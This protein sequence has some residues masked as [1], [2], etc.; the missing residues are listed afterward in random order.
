VVAAPNPSAAGAQY[1]GSLQLAVSPM[2]ELVTSLRSLLRSPRHPVHR[3]WRERVAPQLA[4]LKLTLLPALVDAPILPHFLQPPPELG[5]TLES[6]LG[7]IAALSG[8]E[9]ATELGWAFGRRDDP[10][11]GV[12]QGLLPLLTQP[13]TA[14][15]LLVDE[16]RAYWTIAL[17]ASWSRVEDFL[18]ADVERAG[19]RVPF[20]TAASMS[21]AYTLAGSE[22]DVAN[23]HYAPIS[24]P[25]TSEGWLIATVF[26]WPHDASIVC[27]EVGIAWPTRAPMLPYAPSGL[28]NLWDD[29]RLPGDDALASVVGPA[30]ARIMALL[31]HPTSTTEIANALAMTPGGASQQLA[32]LYGAGLVERS[33]ERRHVYYRLSRR[34]SQL[35]ALFLDDVG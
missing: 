28:A 19:K 27:N 33:R 22:L 25:G 24:V 10:A 6:E 18:L 32:L 9:I 26:S 17:A 30:R 5:N 35:L 4:G 21:P 2:W 34:G 8:A 15:E 3:R 14:T 29:A 20:A 16:L 23:M 13:G 11:A 12:P 1:G 7:M 31:V